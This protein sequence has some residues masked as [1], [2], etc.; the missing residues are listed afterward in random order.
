MAL[1]SSPP[2]TFKNNG[3]CTDCNAASDGWQQVAY[4]VTNG[5]AAF[6]ASYGVLVQF[7]QGTTKRQRLE[8]TDNPMLCFTRAYASGV[9]T[10]WV[11]EVDG[12]SDHPGSG[13]VPWTTAS[14][15]YPFDGSTI[16]YRKVGSRVDMNIL[17]YKSTAGYASTSMFSLP[18]GY[19][20]PGYLEFPIFGRDASPAIGCMLLEVQPTG[21]VLTGF[22]T[23]GWASTWGYGYG[24]CSFFV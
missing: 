13:G 6:T 21:N 23:A 11:L 10:A 20:P 3:T 22:E 15:S 19:R 4:G 16:T 17:I 9:W 12:N 14:C 1:I 8:S 24:Y 5:P 2:A 7:T 18:S